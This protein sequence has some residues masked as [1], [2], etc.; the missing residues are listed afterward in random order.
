MPLLQNCAIDAISKQHKIQNQFSTSVIRIAYQDTLENSPLLCIFEMTHGEAKN[1]I[2]RN[3]QMD[4]WSK[5]ALVDFARAISKAW[6]NKAPWRT[7]PVHDKC[8]YHV[9]GEVEQC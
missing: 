6:E 7:L 4:N 5:E 9:H 1:S 3:D 8:F 2:F